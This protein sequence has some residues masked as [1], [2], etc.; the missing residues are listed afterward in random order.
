M[1]QPLVIIFN[2]ASGPVLPL[3]NLASSTPMDP[4]SGPPPS[5]LASF[6]GSLETRICGRDACRRTYDSCS[7][8]EKLTWKRILNSRNSAGDSFRWFCGDCVKYY[9]GKDSTHVRGMGGL[10]KW[11]LLHSFTDDQPP[12]PLDDIIH[13][14]PTPPHPTPP[15]PT[16][17]H[18][19][20][21]PFIAQD[22]IRRNI[23]SAQRGQG[24]PRPSLLLVV[25]E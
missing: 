18:L 10:S 23:A 9:R 25:T 14:P 11:C 24:M 19:S 22:D 21:S 16:P 12:G 13:L 3:C 8:D 15:H 2:T 7:Q 20:S 4:P 17:P 1:A 5:L 6:T